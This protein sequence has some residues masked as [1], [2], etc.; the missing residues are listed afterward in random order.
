MKPDKMT[1]EERAR[2]EGYA[3]GALGERAHTTR[4]LAEVDRLTAEN[5]AHRAWIERAVA[6][7]KVLEAAR[8]DL[9]AHEAPK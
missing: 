8:A 1:P 5:A 6:R 3:A 9:D 4:A 7:L 2:A